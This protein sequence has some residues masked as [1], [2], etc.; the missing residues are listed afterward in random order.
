MKQ[1]FL[2]VAA[3]L[4]GFVGGILGTRV[5]LAH[6]AGRPEQMIRARSF[7]LV[8]A[9]GH[10]ISYWGVDKGDNAVLSF[11]SHWPVT[12]GGPNDPSGH[13]P[14]PLDNPHNQR[15]AIGVI[16][17][18]PFLMLR[19]PDGKTRVRLY[20]SMYEKPFLLMEDET[21]PRLL[22]GVEQSDTPGPQD[23]DWSLAFYPERARIG[24]YT[25]KI[26]GQTYVRG[27]FGVQRDKV[28]YPYNQP[29]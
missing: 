24:M 10:T 16:A 5:V 14:Q 9:S 18:S 3:L 4:A 26:G 13:P 29:K 27:S 17:D 7:E 22:L 28:K 6:R 23:N 25:E 1:L 20:L 11:A 19:G 21:G 15:M 12:S 8:N 2:I